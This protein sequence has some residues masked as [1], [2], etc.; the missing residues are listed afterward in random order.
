MTTPNHERTQKL[1]KELTAAGTVDRFDL[2]LNA[3]EEAEKRGA[4]RRRGS[5]YVQPR[6]QKDTIDP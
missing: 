4:A 5:P 6:G 1:L 3:L 2:L